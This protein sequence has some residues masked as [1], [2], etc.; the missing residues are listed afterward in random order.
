MKKQRRYRGSRQKIGFFIPALVVLCLIAAAS[1]YVIN[2][3]M[4]FTKE[5]SYFWR[6]AY[7]HH[8]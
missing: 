3:N 8:L 6:Y 5:G 1:L 7:T 4:T 2:N